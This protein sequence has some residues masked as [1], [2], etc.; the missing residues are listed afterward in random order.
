MSVDPKTPR[1]N[2]L[3]GEPGIQALVTTRG[4]LDQRDF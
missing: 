2:E 1:L 3:P 4:R